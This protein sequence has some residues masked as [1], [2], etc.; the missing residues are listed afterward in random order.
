MG[1]FL[2]NQ[3]VK[4]RRQD[5]RRPEWEKLPWTGHPRYLFTRAWEIGRW[6]S[7][8]KRAGEFSEMRSFS[9]RARACGS[10]WMRGQVD[11]QNWERRY[12]IPKNSWHETWLSYERDLEIQDD[13]H[14][15]SEAV[16]Q[17]YQVHLDRMI[18]KTDRLWGDFCRKRYFWNEE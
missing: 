10:D 17:F 15:I 5:I 13:M 16:Y 2:T 18:R 7:Q 14:R 9:G 3:K 6:K 12:E 1:L 4:L 11:P 8:H